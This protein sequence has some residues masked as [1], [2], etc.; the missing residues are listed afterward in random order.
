MNTTLYALR[1]CLSATPYDWTVKSKYDTDFI[2]R[3]SLKL[4]QENIINFYYLKR[5][6]YLYILQTNSCITTGWFLIPFSMR[7]SN[8]IW[9]GQ[10]AFYTLIYSP[11]AYILYTNSRIT[12]ESFLSPY[13]NVLS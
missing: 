7:V 2:K 1:N 10:I 9:L 13:F 12:T 11:P 4:I 5:I 6:T 3:I 8:F